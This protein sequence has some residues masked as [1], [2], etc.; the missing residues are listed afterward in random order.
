[1]RVESTSSVSVALMLPAA[2][3]SAA[4]GV[5]SFMTPDSTKLPSVMVGT[6]RV[7]GVLG[8]TTPVTLMLKVAGSMP[9]GGPYRL[10]V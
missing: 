7:G 2:A 4:M 3:V 10:T 8:T 6:D 5:P 9:K 1:M